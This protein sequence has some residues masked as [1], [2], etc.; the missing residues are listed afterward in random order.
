[1]IRPPLLFYVFCFLHPSLFLKLVKV[2][3]IYNS[4][5]LICIIISPLPWLNLQPVSMMLVFVIGRSASV[6]GVAGKL[7]NVAS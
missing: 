1:M 2:E 7:T 3:I 6:F 5:L 4:L